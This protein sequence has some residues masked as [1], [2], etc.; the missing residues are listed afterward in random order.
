MALLMTLNSLMEFP[1]NLGMVCISSS[2]RIDSEIIHLSRRN[3]PIS[4]TLLWIRIPHLL[5]TGPS[6]FGMCI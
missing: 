4:S 2:R 6:T 3:I 1:C 5:K